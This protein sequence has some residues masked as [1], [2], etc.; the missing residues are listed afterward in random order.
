[1]SHSPR[2]IIYPEMGRE[3]AYFL[4]LFLADGCFERRGRD[5]D[6]STVA[7]SLRESDGYILDELGEWLSGYKLRPRLGQMKRGPSA[8][9]AAEDRKRLRLHSKLFV[10]YLTSELGIPVQ[11]KGKLMGMPSQINNEMASDFIRGVFD[12][13]GHIAYLPSGKFYV[14]TMGALLLL[15]DIARKLAELTS[16]RLLRPTKHNS[17]DVHILHYY[18]R[19][20]A[21]AVCEFL[22]QDH[23]RFFMD[24]KRNTWL[25]FVEERSLPI[26]R[27]V[28][29]DDDETERLMAL[30]Q[31]RTSH[32]VIAEVL[33]RSTASVTQRLH[34]LRKSGTYADA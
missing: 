6:Y 14:C 10:E 31:D 9:A 18:S 24:R 2:P 29:W 25:S 3:L 33:G 16:V 19:A 28:R 34:A 23:P 5:Y 8:S 26:K 17:G 22:Y 13:D 7:I 15:E 11:N 32:G 12:G 21:H 20:E 4:G 27:P 1:M 30:K